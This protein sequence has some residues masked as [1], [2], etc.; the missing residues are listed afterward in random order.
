MHCVSRQS[1]SV[2][3]LKERLLRLIAAQGPISVAHYM[4]IALTD[5]EFGYYA[6]CEPLGRDF[7]TAP[8]VSQIFGELIGLF[9]VQVWENLGQPHSF[10]LVELGPGRGTLMADLLR[11]AKI[12]PAFPEAARIHLI[13]I[14]PRLRANQ[15]KL[16]QGARVEWRKCINNVPEDAPIFLIANE[17]FDALPVRQFIRL[18]NRWRERMVDAA[19][20]DLIFVANPVLADAEIPL[21]LRDGPEE[22]VFETCPPAQALAH[23][24]GRRVAHDG[25]A[26]LIIDYGYSD[27][28]LGDTLQAVKSHRYADPLAEPGDADLTCHVDFAALAR[29]AGDAGARVFGPI[30]QSAFLECLGI[31]ER[32]ERLKSTPAQQA[33]EIETAVERLVSEGQMGTLFKVLAIAGSVELPGFPC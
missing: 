5:P 29:A 10:H 2:S 30:T 18:W 21:P 22:A 27:S 13:E 33:S 19:G 23:E 4:Q 26:A 17:F 9:F 1:D 28:K 7:I 6:D 8:E 11:A 31:R 20:G 16:L 25:G 15:A 3:R 12:R 14:N 24:I 32:A